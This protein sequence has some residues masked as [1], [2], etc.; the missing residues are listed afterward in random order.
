MSQASSP[1]SMNAST[2][3]G[4]IP[5]LLWVRTQTTPDSIASAHRNAGAWRLSTWREMTAQVQRLAAALSNAG[6]QKGDRLAILGQ[7][8]RE[9]LL[10]E[11]AGLWLGAVIV[12]IDPHASVEQLA[13]VLRHSESRFLVTDSIQNLKKVPTEVLDRLWSVSVWGGRVPE[14][15]RGIFHWPDLDSGDGA[16]LGERPALTAADPA[17]LVYTAGTTGSSKGIEYTH[18]HMLVACRSVLNIFPQITSGDTTVCWLPMAHL[19]QR[20][21]NLWAMACGMTSYIVDDPRIL[22]DALREVRPSFFAAV[23]R[24]YEKLA[25]TLRGQPD[26]M[27]AAR[28]LT[29]GNIKFMLTGSAPLPL[30]VAEF[31]NDVG[32]LVLEAYGVTENTVPLATNRPDAYRFGS[33]GQ[34][35]D[36]NEL[37]LADD[38]EV[39]VR[40]PG[41]FEGYYKEQR[42]RLHLFSPDGFYRTGDIGAV[43]AD[44]Y[45]YLTGARRISS[46][47]LG[48]GESRRCGSR[49]RTPRA[50]ILTRWLYSVTGATHLRPYHS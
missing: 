47:P 37:R 41:L 20:M 8:S 10:T 43:D 36:G 45:W 13:F 38:G 40:G 11:L 7:T 1:G 46:R 31:L 12:G 5:E 48:G 50:R 22:V 19:F 24:F 27:A 39:L 21:L 42:R 28:A 14:Q 4:T 15:V 49:Q 18:G 44:G 16:V 33:V 25:H 29:G 17:T 35:F 6:L 34:P 26:P 30:W 32:L 3:P 2:L 23:P 9:W